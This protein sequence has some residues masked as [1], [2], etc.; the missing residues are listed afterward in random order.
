MPSLKYTYGTTIDQNCKIIVGRVTIPHGPDRSA[1]PIPVSFGK[2]FTPGCEPIIS[3]TSVSDRED[4]IYLRAYG[5]STLKPTSLGMVIRV[6]VGCS[7]GNSKK[8]ERS[9]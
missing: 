9:F 3:L 5:Q 2:Y 8:I 6:L 1:K 4:E 7:S